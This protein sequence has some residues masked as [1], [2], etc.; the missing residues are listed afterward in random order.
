MTEVCGIGV[1]IL[2][3][4]NRC[5]G[6]NSPASTFSLLWIGVPARRMCRIDFNIVWFLVDSAFNL[7]LNKIN[8]TLLI[9][10]ENIGNGLKKWNPYI[11]DPCQRNSNQDHVLTILKWILC[12]ELDLQCWNPVL[13]K[14]IFVVLTFAVF[15]HYHTTLVGIR[16]I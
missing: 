1:S 14:T 6:K 5:S 3:T 12:V 7:C 10:S 8:F 2:F 16:R 13:S 4:M 11:L 9:Y 15:T